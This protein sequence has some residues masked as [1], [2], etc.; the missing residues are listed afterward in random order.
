VSFSRINPAVGAAS[1]GASLTTA[2]TA[3]LERFEVRSIDDWSNAPKGVEYLPPHKDQ[4]AGGAYTCTSYSAAAAGLTMNCSVKQSDGDGTNAATPIGFAYNIGLGTTD[5]SIGLDNITAKRGSLQFYYM[6]FAIGNSTH[7]DDTF[8]GIVIKSYNDADYAI[9]KYHCR[10]GS[11]ARV[12]DD[13]TTLTDAQLEAGFRL[14][15]EWDA[16]EGGF[17]AFYSLDDGSTYTEL[18]SGACP[19]GYVSPVTDTTSAT[20]SSPNTWSRFHDGRAVYFTLGTNQ[21]LAS[22]FWTARCTDL[23]FHEV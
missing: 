9:S 7:T 14:R 8:F 21:N 15:I 19:T 18:G 1:G 6:D 5:V 13:G 2:Q 22:D 3:T 12:I 11:S 16:A 23:N 20:I 17:K 10:A 4:R